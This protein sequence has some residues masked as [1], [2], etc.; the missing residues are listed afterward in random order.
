[1]FKKNTVLQK[2]VSSLMQVFEEM[3]LF[4]HEY[5]VSFSLRFSNRQV[6][7]WLEGRKVTWR[8]SGQG[9]LIGNDDW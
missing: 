8:T 6:A 4:G 5:W 3:V 7:A 9:N 2:K 1:M